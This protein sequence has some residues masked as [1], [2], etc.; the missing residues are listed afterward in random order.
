[1]HCLARYVG[2]LF[3]CRRTIARL[4]IYLACHVSTGRLVC[5][6]V[7]W[8]PQPAPPLPPGPALPRVARRIVEGG[9]PALT[10][11]TVL[12]SEPAAALAAQGSAAPF[13][14]AALVA[15]VSGGGLSLMACRPLTG[16][17]HQVRGAALWGCSLVSV[18]R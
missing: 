18:S 7:G 14:D 16:R 8:A 4:C 6:L 11:F 1:M 5:G 3:A 13:S 15:A 2:A 9:K 10:E 17:T 12:A